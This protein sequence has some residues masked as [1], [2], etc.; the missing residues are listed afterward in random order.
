MPNPWK[1]TRKQTLAQRG[2]K[3]A[4]SSPYATNGKK[5]QSVAWDIE[6]PTF[7]LEVRVVQISKD[8]KLT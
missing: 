2:G 3:E 6:Q 7:V 4:F 1:D 5:N 8:A